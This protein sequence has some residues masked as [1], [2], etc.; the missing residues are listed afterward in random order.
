ME[1][2]RWSPNGAASWKLKSLHLSRVMA[3]GP[4]VLTLALMVASIL[5]G[6]FVAALVLS[7]VETYRQCADE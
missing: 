2:A 6:L 3:E 7:A 5:L 1:P 4:D